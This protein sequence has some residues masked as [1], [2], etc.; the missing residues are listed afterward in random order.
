[1]YLLTTV[2]QMTILGAVAVP[3]S[4]NLECTAASNMD[5]LLSFCED[6]ILN[7]SLPMHYVATHIDPM[8][9]DSLARQSSETVLTMATSCRL[10]VISDECVESYRQYTCASNFLYCSNDTNGGR[11]GLLQPCRSMCHQ[12]CEDCMLD[13]CPCAHLPETDCY[14]YPGTNSSVSS[15]GVAGERLTSIPLVVFAF[16]ATFW[17]QPRKTT[18]H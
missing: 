11:P 6:L 5:G 14:K 9:Q 13:V 7:S 8:V 18:E 1:M 16:L 4:W 3:H 2:F 10:V 15:S 12:Y 17:S